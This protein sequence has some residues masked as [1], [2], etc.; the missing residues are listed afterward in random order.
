MQQ[1]S[2]LERVQWVSS[3]YQRLVAQAGRIGAAPTDS[4][5]LALQERL[6]VSLSVGLLP[7]TFLWSVIYF[8]AG[9]PLSA[10]IPGL[11]MIIAPI[12]TAVFAWNRNLVVYRFVQLLIFL[13]LPWLLMM[14]LGGFK[15]SSVVIIWAALCPLAALLL[16]D[17]R[18][19]VF[20]ILG[21]VWLLIVSAILQPFLV[22]VGLPETFVTWFFVLNIGAVIAIAF[23]LL[24]YFVSQRNFF[25]VNRPGFAG[26]PLV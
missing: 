5:E 14:S 4:A 9:A 25:Q 20:W 23:T 10:A 8:A 21:F 12:N 16:E 13:I 22:P 26:G 17:S 7:L 1:G 3:V 6:I 11:Y 15:N 24:Y 18:R 19:T 2:T